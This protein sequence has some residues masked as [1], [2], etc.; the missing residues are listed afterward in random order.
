[1]VGWG[2]S[3]VDM[4]DF[5]ELLA[6]I[7]VTFLMDFI[8]DFQKNRLDGPLSQA[9]NELVRDVMFRASLESAVETRI[10]LTNRIRDEERVPTDEELRNEARAEMG[11]PITDVLQGVV[12]GIMSGESL[13][14]H[15]EKIQRYILNQQDRSE[16]ISNLLRTKDYRRLVEF[17]RVR[18]NLE[19]KML[20]AATRGD[21]NISEQ[22]ALFSIINSEASKLENKV[23]AG[24]SNISDIMALMTKVDYSLQENDSKLK[25]KMK[26]TSASGREIVRRVIHKLRK[27]ATAAEPGK[28]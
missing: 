13:A 8:R 22:M 11:D 18:D 27:V 21:L 3:Y 2:G 7:P 23:E 26:G 9:A 1:M 6:P 19:G 10:E 12:D 25:E 28:A 15:S 14:Q 4:A 5:P 17:V 24:A 16:L 20:E